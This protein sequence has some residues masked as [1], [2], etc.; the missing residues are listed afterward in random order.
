MS[1][2][3]EKNVPRNCRKRLHNTA[4][5]LATVVWF[6]LFAWID[7]DWHH[8]GIM[9]GAVSQ[10]LDNKLLFR[11]VFC[12]YGPLSV[13]LQCIPCALFGSEVLVIRLTTVFFYGLIAVLSVG[14]WKRFVRKPFMLIWYLCFF[15]LCPFYQV[16]FH[17]WSSV[18]A[19]FFMLWGT[20]LQLRYF[21]RG[22][23]DPR[24]LRFS[25]VCA[26]AAFLCRTPCGVV[27]FAAGGAT[28]FLSG[29]VRK[30]KGRFEGLLSYCG[31]AAIVLALFAGYLTVAGA[32]QDYFR[33]CFS[34]VYNFARNSSGGNYFRG[35]LYNICSPLDP[36]GQ[37]SWFW[38]LLAG[39]TAVWAVV[40]FR[41]IFRDS[42]VAL[43]KTLPLLAVLLLC[44]A[45]LHQYYP[46]PCL[47]HFW[48][49]AIP[50]FGLYAL[51]AQKIRELKLKILPE[52]LLFS[53][54]WSPLFSPICS[55]G[56]SAFMRL[57]EIPR[58]E[59][60]RLPGIR[61]SLVDK[62][63]QKFLEK[64]R[65][66]FEAQ[67]EELR[68]RGVINNTPDGL[69]TCLLP[70]PPKYYH[71]MFVNWYDLVYP[72]YYGYVSYYLSTQSPLILTTLVDRIPGCR[73]IF[74]GRRHNKTFYFFAPLSYNPL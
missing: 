71:P 22:L 36:Y 52:I 69:F 74:T 25:G 72:N 27:T 18:F 43:E 2:S 31:G 53:L 37:G 41:K 45:S 19:L 32:W 38:L 4:I 7:T 39:L 48:W 61:Y 6:G 56:I 67:P 10:V 47:R 16:T 17:P 23:S 70:H 35:V 33:Q 8:D 28:L 46:V 60:G 50:V 30:E 14:I 40:I 55:R 73:L 3:S 11:N 44:G 12:Q 9:L 65:A 42:R 13:W 5:F 34:F 63:D 15:T 57:R 68:S 24:L 58:M 20:E 62:D 59:I 54:L 51:T 49:A 26:A 66:A 21:E 1:V 29:I 64:I